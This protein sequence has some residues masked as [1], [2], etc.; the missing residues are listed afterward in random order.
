MKP[1]LCI[2]FDADNTLADREHDLVR[3]FSSALERVGRGGDK[4][5]LSLL[6]GFVLTDGDAA[7]LTDI[8]MPHV[9]TAYRELNRTHVRDLFEYADMVCGFCGRGTEAEAAFWEAYSQP[10]TPVEGAVETV[11]ALQKKY[12]VFAVANGL[13]GVEKRRLSMFGLDDV[14]VSEELGAI[15]PHAEFFRAVLH[16]LG[17]DASRCLYVGDSLLTDIAGSR[18]CGMDSYWF[19]RK[20]AACPDGVWEIR[21]LKDLVPLL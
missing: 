17:V 7:G 6:C 3:A 11:K 15:K 16:L 13:S 21:S 1:Y 19:N 20:G 9:R 18:T 4:E 12:R 14:F 8:R 2:L 5:A 10:A